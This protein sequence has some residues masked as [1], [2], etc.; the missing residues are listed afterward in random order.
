MFHACTSS[1]MRPS[2]HAHGS[3]AGSC[4]LQELATFGFRG[5]ALS[6]LCAL[7]E[8]TITHTHGR[9]NRLGCGWNMIIMAP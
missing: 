1:W 4:V 8:V 5:E 7:G 3:Q 6:S 9:T 2:M